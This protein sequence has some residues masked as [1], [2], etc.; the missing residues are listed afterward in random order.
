MYGFSRNARTTSGGTVNTRFHEGVDI[1]PMMRDERGEP[2]DTVVAIDDG[3]V[4]HV[5]SIA[6][7]SNYGK[8]I[9]VQH[10]WD[11]SPF[12]SL[13]AHLN[14]TW[15]ETGQGIRQGEPLGKLGY[16]GAGITRSRA[17][18]HFEITMLV[19]RFFDTWY[20]NEYGDGRNYHGH[21]NGLNL[22]GINVAQ[23]YKRLCET[24][25]LG[26]REFIRE[27]HRPFYTVRLPRVARL[28]LLSRYPWLLTESA[29]PRHKSWEITFD[30]S[31]L[32]LAVAPSTVSVDGPEIDSAV[33]SPFPYKYVTKYRLLG[34]G[35]HP[36]LSNSGKRFIRLVGTEPDS[37]TL[38]SM[39]GLFAL[40][41]EF[42][43]RRNNPPGV[44]VEEPT[45][46]PPP[47]FERADVAVS[48]RATRSEDATGSEG[49]TGSEEPGDGLTGD[50]SVPART[51]VSAKPV[52]RSEWH[53]PPYRF[54]W[55]I[56]PKHV[57]DARVRLAPIRLQIAV[58][59]D[60]LE[61]VGVDQVVVVAPVLKR[62]GISA[63]RP[64]QLSESIW[65]IELSVNRPSRTLKRLRELDGKTLRLNL[66]LVSD[67]ERESSSIDVRILVR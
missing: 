13:Y 49:A 17:H 27:E 51:V 32:P 16:T 26:I 40:P 61:S 1:A 43:P 34:S 23:L 12:Y 4:V 35:D 15:V 3:V 66:D 9:V 65:A 14:D 25:G 63:G 19:N 59:E 29:L 38:A 8:Y 39:S 18:L 21:F 5:N 52:A 45:E 48:E 67:D 54:D 50:V 22:A 31:G 62:Y 58:S 24:P 56:N 41:S 42:N 28:D 33:A 10:I 46:P 20:N 57:A 47:L 11:G 53:H 64:V 44:S 36:R 2:L 6:S 7:H 30:R 37:A 60:E 55:E